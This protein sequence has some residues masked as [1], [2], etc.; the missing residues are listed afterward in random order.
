METTEARVGVTTAEQ[1][2]SVGDPGKFDDSD[3]WATTV[4]LSNHHPNQSLPQRAAHVNTRVPPRAAGPVLSTGLVSG[5]SE[6][7]DQDREFHLEFHLEFPYS[8]SW[9]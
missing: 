3:F 4:N 1:P 6:N 5:K 8:R 7:Q 2:E 9:R